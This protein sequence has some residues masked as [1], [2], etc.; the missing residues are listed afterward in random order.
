MVIQD[1]KMGGTCFFV[2]L[3]K[4]NDSFLH[5]PFPTPFTDYCLVNVGGKEAYSF[6]DG[7]CGYHHIKIAGG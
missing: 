3:W 7:L 4:L 5:D 2:E 6:T 1:K